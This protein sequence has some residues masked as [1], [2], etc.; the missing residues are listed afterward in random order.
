MFRVYTMT[1]DIGRHN[2]YYKSYVIRFDSCSNLVCSIPFE[3]FLKSNNR[4]Q[5]ETEKRLKC[6]KNNNKKTRKINDDND[7]FSQFVF[8][9]NERI[10]LPSLSVGKHL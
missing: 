8:Y 3:Y 9:V 7:A 5:V 10:L 6:I 2:K 1:K 4:S